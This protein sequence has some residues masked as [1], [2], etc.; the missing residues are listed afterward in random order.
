MSD[1]LQI[2]ASGLRA[3]NTKLA[4]IGENVSNAGTDGYT[5]RTVTLAEAS[6]NSSSSVSNL[7]G[8]RVQSVQRADDTFAATAKRSA[9]TDAAAATARSTWLGN[10]QTALADDA[11]GVGQSATTI[12][13]A[14]QAL[15]ADPGSTGNRKAFLSAIDQTAQAFNTTAKQL[16]NAADDITAAAQGAVTTINQSLDQL[17]N[18]NSQ[19]HA[20]Q[21][22]TAAQANLLD[23]R[24]KMLDSVSANIGIDVQ[25]A[26]DGSATVQ[27]AGGG[28][29]L[30]YSGK[31]A[32]RLSVG[33]T[34]G[35]LSLN[36]TVNGVDQPITAPG[37]TLGGLVD[38]ADAVATQQ[39]RLNDLATDFANQ[40]NSWSAAGTDANGA[41]GAPLVSGTSAA[42]LAVATT[43]PTKV[44]AAKGGVS[45]GNLLTLDGLRGTSGIEQ[46]WT[47]QVTDVGRQVA[48][49]KTA[50]TAASSRSDAANAN[51]TAATGVDTDSE[52]ADLVRYQQAYNA[53]AKVIQV[54]R[55]TMQALLQV[56]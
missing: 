6:A 49:A 43:D 33:A 25:F 53:A 55:D 50:A 27:I 56:I 16:Q 26:A 35:R 44:P 51:F 46:S 8:V 47:R 23:Q 1:L 40:L 15:A 37:G 36:A 28:A 29:T 2:G 24:D 38:S 32:A 17:D 12:F 54:A 18:I 3:F 48:A 11:T 4:A 52:A 41:A 21:P 9:A 45:N 5:R 39:T 7:N 10:V 14:G 30:A 31:S 22:G 19:L 13:T 34:G 42:T 20:V